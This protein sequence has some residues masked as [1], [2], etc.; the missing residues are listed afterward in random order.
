MPSDGGERETVNLSLGG[1]VR[2][3]GWGKRQN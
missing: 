3:I 1:G 2:L